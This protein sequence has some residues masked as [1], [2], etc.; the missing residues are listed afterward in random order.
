MKRI[1]RSC[2]RIFL[3]CLWVFFLVVIFV[4]GVLRFLPL[5]GLS[6]EELD[7][8]FLQTAE[9]HRTVPH[10][11]LSYCLKPGWSTSPDAKHGQKSHNSL[12]LR[13]EEITLQKPEGAYRIVCLGGSSTYGNTPSTDAATWP[14]RLEFHLR[15]A[16]PDRSIQVINAGAPGYS[17]FESTINL[18]FRMLEF[19][20]DL[21]IVYHSINDMRC[22]LYKDPAPDNS[23]WRAPWPV[24]RPSPIEPYLKKSMCYLI[25]RRY[26]TN[27]LIDRADINYNA[28]V[29]PPPGN[30]D[31]YARGDDISF[32]GFESFKRNL[33]NITAIAR[34]HEA[35]VLFA[36]QA[37]DEGDITSPKSG[38][39][40]LKAMR[41]MAQILR[42]TAAELKVPLVDA[43][44]ILEGEAEQQKSEKGEENVFSW[45]V[46][47]T[48]EGA[49]L[50]AR[51][52]SEKILA[53]GMIP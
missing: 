45:E 17:T 4:E 24:F 2:A 36:T 35:R 10:P 11:Y 19:E 15:E 27:Y 21:I 53:E 8:P 16:R 37:L 47:L 7:P 3:L 52:F 20:P 33:K 50:L 14:A 46:H 34:A 39:N 48:D 13:G 30:T 9:V 28:I 41:L 5:P 31:W 12:G 1:M 22:A 40:Q 38:H 44:K 29:D 32:Q 42:E 23:H 6:R 26:F 25:W 49:D 43:E 18:A 51:I